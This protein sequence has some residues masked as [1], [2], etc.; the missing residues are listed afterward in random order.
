MKI[1]PGLWGNHQKFRLYV[2]LC[3]VVFAGVIFATDPP[4]Y[5]Q[6]KINVGE[7]PKNSEI[8]VFFDVGRG[9]VERD[10]NSGKNIKLSAHSSY[11][12]LKLPSA[13]IKRI[14]I[15]PGNNARLW[16]FKNIEINYVSTVTDFCRK[17][18]EWSPHDLIQNFSFLQNISPFYI[19]DGFLEINAI[20]S[21]PY[22]IYSNPIEFTT[23]L[24]DIAPFLKD[25]LELD[26]R[27]RAAILALCLVLFIL[28]Q[29]K[30]EKLVQW[31]QNSQYLVE[32]V[33]IARYWLPRGLLLINLLV[34]LWIIGQPPESWVYLK[35]VLGMCLTFLIPG[36][37]ISR[38]FGL[39][40][41]N[42]NY[43]QIAIISLGTG[44]ATITSLLFLLNSFELPIGSAAI[45]TVLLFIAIP[46]MISLYQ[47]VKKRPHNQ[48]GSVFSNE[49]LIIWIL[50]N[51]L[52]YRFMVPTKGLIVAP[53]HDPV[54]LSLMG[55]ELVRGGYLL[56]NTSIF[57]RFYPPFGGYIMAVLSG[58]TDI[59]TPKIV[60]ILTN[61][62]NL[63]GGLAFSVFANFFIRNKNGYI[64][65]I[66]AYSFFINFSSN[67]YY[68]AGKNAQLISYFFLFYT[69]ILV[70]KSLQSRSW[71]LKL[72]TALAVVTS[73]MVHYSNLIVIVYAPLLIIIGYLTLYLKKELRLP[74][75]MRELMHWTSI[76]PISAILFIHYLTLKGDPFS[77][78]RLVSNHLVSDK[79]FHRS[80]E[81]YLEIFWRTFSNLRHQEGNSIFL[82]CILG[83][84]YLIYHTLKKP[85]KFSLF[86][87]FM[88]F[89][90]FQFI[91]SSLPRVS[92]IAQ[93]QL[94]QVMVIGMF[95]FF[96]GLFSLAR[97]KVL[98]A[99][100]FVIIVSNGSQ[101]YQRLI[102]KYDRARFYSVVSSADLNAFVWIRKNVPLDQYFLPGNVKLRGSA[103]P[104]NLDAVLYLQVYTARQSAIAFYG[105]NRFHFNETDIKKRY[106]QLS[107]NLSDLTV[108]DYLTARNIKYIYFGNHRPWG[109]GPLSAGELTEHP[110]I[111]APVFDEGGVKIF[112]IIHKPESE[113]TTQS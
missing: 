89:V 43:L 63:F 62:F 78:G 60:L 65:S 107:K 71:G 108:L 76:V 15:D 6:M 103:Q 88:P 74:Q 105:G 17:L 46:S 52:L 40:T 79:L 14:R 109:G 66:L 100:F 95:W 31:F 42:D 18:L 35:T 5:L 77:G 51:L 55:T 85:E 57:T 48:I 54:A 93:L 59:P 26:F 10:S 30:A 97:Y 87:L 45:Q 12:L 32:K 91:Q 44:V 36:F 16:E 41:H 68:R 39:L 80:F 111:Y 113:V 84:L 34:T 47:L 81:Q 90:M 3:F 19:K 67:L 22:F 33:P 21:D 99:I 7:V 49:S 86:F 50:V 70:Y 72:F 112:M 11:Y 27:V 53:L 25:A 4:F 61:L 82:I 104:Y 9:F 101:Q 28:L 98:Y 106:Q 69:L 83:Y 2:L 13:H 8:K 1:Y 102:K 56:K 73:I 64:F 92:Q 23:S 37:L 20:G 96:V 29:W 75:L 38:I 58:V 24:S 110:K 94:Y